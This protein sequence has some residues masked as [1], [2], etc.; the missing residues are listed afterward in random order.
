MS[1][2]ADTPQPRGLTAADLLAHQAALEREAREAVPFSFTKGGCTHARGYIRQPVW[3][4]TTCGGGGVCAG[5]SVGCHAEHDLVELF[6]KRSFRCDCGTLSMSQRTRAAGASS[7]AAPEMPTPCSLRPKE[8]AVATEN[9]D[10]AYG[11]NFAGHFCRCARGETYDPETEDETMFQ[12]LACEDWFHESCTSLLGGLAPPGS[13]AASTAASGAGPS[14]TSQ[15]AQSG[16]EGRTVSAQGSEAVGTEASAPQKPPQG[17]GAEQ[18]PVKTSTTSSVHVPIDVVPAEDAPLPLIAHES[19]DLLLCSSCV[20]APSHEIL[21]HYVGAAGWGAV[22]PADKARL[23][24]TPLARGNTVLG[25]EPN[26]DLALEA[27][28]LARS[29]APADDLSAGA[30]HALT[31]PEP[32]QAS[33]RARLDGDEGLAEASAASEQEAKPLHS[34]SQEAGAKAAEPAPVPGPSAVASADPSCTLPPLPAW[35]APEQDNVDGVRLDIFLSDDF[36]SRICRCAECIP[37]FKALPYVLESEATY[38]PPRSE[39]SSEAGSVGGAS[40]ASSSYD[41]GMAALQRLPREQ[42]LESLEAYGRLRDALFEQ[43]LRPCQ[44]SG[45]EVDEATIRAFFARH[46]EQARRGG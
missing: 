39:V 21:R 9:E 14:T 23:K 42:M 17:D 31:S 30:K 10:N 19:F 46:R 29:A 16:G 38:S 34:A 27:T 1:P 8:T 15:P 12:C 11:R 32:E 5:C 13:A 43:V 44:E 45:Q 3:A 25:L 2:S 18:V 6:A 20:R 28:E 24:P 4:C 22:V 40:H 33:K 36:R 37:R 26:V 35:A 41:R 7:S